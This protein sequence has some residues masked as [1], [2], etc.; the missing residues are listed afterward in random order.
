MPS[1]NTTVHPIPAVRLG[2]LL[3]VFKDRYV[4]HLLL[5]SCVVFILAK[6]SSGSE[7]AAGIVFLG[8]SALL[9]SAAHRALTQGHVFA[10]LSVRRALFRAVVIVAVIGLFVSLAIA[11][12]VPV[13][14]FVFLA[15]GAE[16]A[17]IIDFDPRTAGGRFVLA[18]ISLGGLYCLLRL[19]PV[20]VVQYI[21]RDSPADLWKKTWHIIAIF[22]DL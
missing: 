11:V 5:P 19:W 6:L 4:S 3:A 10:E 2:E 15:M 1:P 21:F 12:F 13:L 14:F 17:P 7:I 20:Y 22:S 8:A 18:G 16:L 9:V